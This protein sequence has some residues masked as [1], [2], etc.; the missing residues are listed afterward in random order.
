VGLDQRRRGR[1]LWEVLLPASKMF[2]DNRIG[3]LSAMSL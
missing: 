1:E 2:G 3:P